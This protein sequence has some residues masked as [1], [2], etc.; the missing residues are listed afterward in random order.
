MNFT[1]IEFL[2]LWGAVLSSGLLCWTVYRARAERDRILVSCFIGGIINGD[3]VTKEDFLVFKIHNLGRQ[4]FVIT[5]L[6]GHC[7]KKHFTV[8]SPGLPKTVEP[9]KCI[10]QYTGD[11]SMLGRPDLTQLW[12]M[13]SLGKTWQIDKRNLT[14]IKDYI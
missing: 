12:V 2:A 14:I 1:I 3:R 6:G 8:P 10:N 11:L 5:H 9:G 4:Q 13:D 7:K